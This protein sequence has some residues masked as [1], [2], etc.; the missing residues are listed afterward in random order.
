MRRLLAAGASRPTDKHEIGIRGLPE[1]ADFDFLT[2]SG[3]IAVIH[4]RGVLLLDDWRNEKMPV[5]AL[6]T[7]FQAALKRLDILRRVQQELA[8]MMTETKKI[9]HSKRQS[10]VVS[11]IERLTALR[12]Q[13]YTTLQQTETHA[14]SHD[15][16]IFRQKLEDRW[17][18]GGQLA[19][20]FKITK[21]LEENLRAYSQAR[22]T[23]FAS[24]I[25]TIGFP[26]LVLL[27]WLNFL[28][29]EITHNSQPFF[30]FLRDK[31]MKIATGSTIYVLIIVLALWIIMHGR[32]RATGAEMTH[33]TR[34]SDREP[35]PAKRR[36][37][38]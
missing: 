2:L 20:A 13:V 17:G 9:L 38:S 27:S 16:R 4:R 32:R 12:V 18:I 24:T 23:F 5:D 21:D 33:G 19:E 14:D 10:P 22:T 8:L 15:V 25:A 31:G 29:E 35:E 6:R 7:E 28:R 30:D 34:A 36:E 3:G 26:L 11:L 1:E 37:K